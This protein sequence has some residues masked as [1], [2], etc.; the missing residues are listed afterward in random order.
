MEPQL[1]KPGRTSWVDDVRPQTDGS[2]RHKTPGHNSAPRSRTIRASGSARLIWQA[3]AQAAW[4]VPEVRGAWLLL[5][6]HAHRYALGCHTLPA[7]TYQVSG[8]GPLAS[9][10]SGP[11][12]RM[13]ECRVVDHAR[14]PVWTRRDHSAKLLV[15]VPA[16]FF[17]EDGP[18]P[19][20]DALELLKAC[21]K[22]PRLT[23]IP[24]IIM[25]SG[26]LLRAK[27]LE[28]GMNAYIV[29]P[30]SPDEP[31]EALKKIGAWPSPHAPPGKG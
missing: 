22:D 7:G 2:C 23:K 25:G 1:R 16:H 10:R 20:T 21:K 26:K 29:T 31:Q 18:M 19:E 27:A 3:L 12:T 6:H 13:F 9:N 8:A 4:H 11:E 28:A 5:A 24:F 15:L 30:V 14:N 17:R